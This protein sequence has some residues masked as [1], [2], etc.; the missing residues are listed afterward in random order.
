MT[1]AVSAT[2]LRNSF[3]FKEVDEDVLQK[4][5]QHCQPMQLDAGETLFEQDSTPDAMY[6]LEDGQI[7]VIR[8]YPDGYEVVLATEVPFYVIGELS[9]L[10][11][12]P[13]T[14]SVV[15]VGDCDL[16]KLG[17]D[18]VF[19]ICEQHPEVAVRALTHLGNRLYQLNLLVRESGIGDVA[20]RVASVLLLLSQGEAGLIA[21]EVNITRLSRATALDADVV[22][23]LLRQWSEA[24]I[25]KV[26]RLQMSIE[27]IE[28]LR[29]IAG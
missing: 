15:A 5:A 29:H 11:N 12:Q 6:F 18:A 20:A 2:I 25:I 22:E 19:A 28:S 24:G 23:S 4:I 1:T 9:M 13:R 17:R 14:G 8:H 21:G 7:H 3:L 27:N 26:N 10:A 16:V